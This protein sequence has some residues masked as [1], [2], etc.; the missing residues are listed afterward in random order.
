[1]QTEAPTRVQA[2][3]R[4]LAGAAKRSHDAASTARALA[5][6]CVALGMAFAPLPG[7]AVVLGFFDSLGLYGALGCIGS[8]L[9]CFAGALALRRL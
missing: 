5:L 9:A 7:L 4:P 3:R 6:A 1:M 8:A 2:A